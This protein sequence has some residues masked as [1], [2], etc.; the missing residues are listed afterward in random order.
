[1]SHPKAAPES[2]SHG[3]CSSQ[4]TEGE[5]LERQLWSYI[6]SLDVKT[7]EQKIAHEFQSIHPDGARN[8]L[9]E[10]ELIKKLH[11]GN[12]SFS[13]FKSTESHDTII[14]TYMISADE[15][16]AGQHLSHKTTPRLSIWKKSSNSGWQWIAHANLHSLSHQEHG[17]PEQHE[18]GHHDQH[19]HGHG[20]QKQGQ[21]RQHCCE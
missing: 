16:I 20:Q 1:M 13:N 19:E 12:F 10:L 2:Q 7:L 15:N 8:K 3:C 11:L 5:K 21:H 4:A 14:V 6:K 18:N 17:H 9:Q